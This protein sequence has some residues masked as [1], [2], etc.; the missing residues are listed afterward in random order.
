MLRN[1]SPKPIKNWRRKKLFCGE[2]R[3]AQMSTYLLVGRII[4]I[5]NKSIAVHDDERE[6]GMENTNNYI[7]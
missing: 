5:L 6:S 7:Y 2:L 1:G 3:I 4:W